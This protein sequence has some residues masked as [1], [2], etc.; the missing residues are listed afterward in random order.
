MPFH[1]S[2][3]EKIVKVN[4][5]KE[6]KLSYKLKR[7]LQEIPL[8]ISGLESELK[9]MQEKA[10]APDFFKL[11]VDETKMILESIIKLEY[12]IEALMERWETLELL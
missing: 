2:R 6:F 4:K 1:P 8:K 11:P 12:E 3:I 9:V 10:N 5:K 7:E